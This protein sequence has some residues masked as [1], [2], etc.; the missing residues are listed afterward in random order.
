MVGINNTGRRPGY[1]RPRRDL[2][3]RDAPHS[4]VLKTLLSFSLCR[5]GFD[6]GGCDTRTRYDDD[7]LEPS[8]RQLSKRS[9]CDLQK[10]GQAD[11]EKDLGLEKYGFARYHT[12]NKAIRKVDAIRCA[13][14]Y[15]DDDSVIASEG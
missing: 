11:L 14:N 6:A 9:D 2:F 10:R 1:W 7:Q 3:N 13:S 15:V 5:N 12:D 4:E 8:F